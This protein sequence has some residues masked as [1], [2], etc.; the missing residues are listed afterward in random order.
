MLGHK[1]YSVLSARERLLPTSCLYVQPDESG[2]P[3][4]GFGMPSFSENKLIE[5]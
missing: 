2:P 1:S 5:G 3:T 4:G